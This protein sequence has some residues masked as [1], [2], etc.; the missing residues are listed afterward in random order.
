ML[1]FSSVKKIISPASLLPLGNLLKLASVNKWSL[2]LFRFYWGNLILF[3]EF[4]TF[5]WLGNLILFLEFF[6]FFIILLTYSMSATVACLN[7]VL[8]LQPE[9]LLSGL[10]IP[11]TQF[12]CPAALLYNIFSSLD[13]RLFFSFNPSFDNLVSE[14]QSI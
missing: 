13:N 6:L 2:I 1:L 8:A 10:D 14:M 3:L 4:F 11:A 9:K 12:N 7:F 5:F